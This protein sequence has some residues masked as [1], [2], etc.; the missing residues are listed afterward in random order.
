MKK[1][2]IF[3][4]IFKIPVSQYFRADHRSVTKR[5]YWLIEYLPGTN[6]LKPIIL[7][8]SYVKSIRK[9]CICYNF[10]GPDRRS[11]MV[12]SYYHAYYYDCG[13]ANIHVFCWPS[14]KMELIILRIYLFKQLI[15]VMQRNNAQP[16]FRLGQ[17]CRSIAV[18]I[19]V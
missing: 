3:K 13:L 15:Y 7:I 10:F 18:C 1:L 2:S 4:G 11:I 19:A 8:R 14:R 12:P 16:V 9:S 17:Y 6:N 5:K